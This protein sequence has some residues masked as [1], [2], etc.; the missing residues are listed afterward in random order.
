MLLLRAW[1]FLARLAALA[2]THSH[3]LRVWAAQAV[4]VPPEEQVAQVAQVVQVAHQAPVAQRAQV[5]FR[6]AHAQQAQALP[7]QVAHPVV[8]QVAHQALVALAVQAVAQ[9]PVVA[10][11]LAVEPQVL[12]VRVEPVARARLASQ[13]APSAKSSNSAATRHHLEAH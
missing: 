6:A 13:S 12:S 4:H 2:T 10:V 7:V 1:A 9:V 8:L 5:V 3:L 11:V